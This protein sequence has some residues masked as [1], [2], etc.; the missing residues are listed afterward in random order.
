M[1]AFLYVFLLASV[2]LFVIAESPNPD[3]SEKEDD[4]TATSKLNAVQ[5]MAVSSLYARVGGAPQ[6]TLSPNGQAGECYTCIGCNTITATTPVKTCPLSSDY[7][8]QNKCVVYEEKYAQNDMKWVIRGCASE[9]NTCDEIRDAYKYPIGGT[10][11][12][13]C[14]DCEGNRCNKSSISHALSDMTIIFFVIITSLLTKTLS[15]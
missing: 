14:R 11:L 4:V 10:T 7:R 6:Q 5:D 1:R 3:P 9:R 8:K 13:S 12:V 2:I 15:S